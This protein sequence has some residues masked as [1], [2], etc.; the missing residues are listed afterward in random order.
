M[1]SATQK[2]KTQKSVI[3]HAGLLE[4]AEGFN[5]SADH[6]DPAVLQLGGA[7]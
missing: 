3:V 7:H 2:L 6:A 5:E 4:T 1:V